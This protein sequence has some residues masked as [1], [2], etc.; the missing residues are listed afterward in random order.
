MN[1]RIKLAKFQ[2]KSN[3]LKSDKYMPGLTATF[4]VKLQNYGTGMYAKG[5]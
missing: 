2:D 3:T 4:M 1:V 5:Y